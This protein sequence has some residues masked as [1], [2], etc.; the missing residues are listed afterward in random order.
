LN[1]NGRRRGELGFYALIIGLIASCCVIF[2][3]IYPVVIR[4]LKKR[5][6]GDLTGAWEWTASGGKYH[7]TMKLVQTGSKISGTMFDEVAGSKGELTGTIVL[8]RVQLSRRYRSMLQEYDLELNM[9]GEKLKGS[10][11]GQRDPSVGNDFRAERTQD[12]LGEAGGITHKEEEV[13]KPLEINV[14]ENVIV[15]EF[16]GSARF[17]KKHFKVLLLVIVIM[18][19]LPITGYC[20]GGILGAIIGGS[21]CNVGVFLLGRKA[22]EELSS[23]VDHRQKED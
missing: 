10:F 20:L 19:I 7:G 12:L 14:H 17:F 23:L 1:S 21:A 6:S 13:R 11:T 18:I 16:V 5:C 22:T 2:S 8:N 9:T 3:F 15:S 4:L